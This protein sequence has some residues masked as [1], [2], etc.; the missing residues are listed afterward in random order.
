MEKPQGRKSVA[1]KKETVAFSSVAAPADGLAP[2]PDSSFAAD[3][4]RQRLQNVGEARSQGNA[5]KP[6]PT[7]G[8]KVREE[9]EAEGA[10]PEVEDEEGAGDEGESRQGLQGGP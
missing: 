2:A 5:R 8:E 6:F 9:A 3:V 4:R 10:G 1:V 7:S